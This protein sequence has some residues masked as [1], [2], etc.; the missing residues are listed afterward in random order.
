M[1]EKKITIAEKIEAIKKFLVENNAN[2]E[3]INF[4]DERLE[5]MTEKADKA[6]AKAAEK[7]AGSDGLVDAI[8]KVLTPELQTP[9]AI[10]DAVEGFE[11]VTRAKVIAR[12]KGLIEAGLAVKELNAE[13]KMC[14]KLC[15]KVEKVD[16]L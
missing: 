10:A 12:M 3:L 2:E 7:K 13:K 9:D 4:C 14:Y 5:K 15:H 11:D 1:A 8:L 16:A 6:K